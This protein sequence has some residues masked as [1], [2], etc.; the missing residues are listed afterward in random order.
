MD[1]SCKYQAIF[2]YKTDS[3]SRPR[4][5]IRNLELNNFEDVGVEDMTEFKLDLNDFDVIRLKAK[6]IDERVGDAVRFASDA[7]TTSSQQS[8]EWANSWSAT[9]TAN[10]QCNLTELNAVTSS[11]VGYYKD[12]LEDAEDLASLR[13]D[14]MSTVDA[15]VSYSN[16]ITLTTG[17]RVP[18]KC[19][20]AYDSLNTL[21]EHISELYST[22]SWK[23]LKICYIDYPEYASHTNI[24]ELTNVDD[25]KV[26][27]Q[28]YLDT[29]VSDIKTQKT[30]L[31]D[32]SYE[33]STF[34]ASVEEFEE[35]YSEC[36]STDTVEGIVDDLYSARLRTTYASFF[37]DASEIFGSLKTGL[38]ALTCL[39]G[40][41]T[42]AFPGLAPA[43]VVCAGLSTIVSGC[44][45]ASE[46]CEA[47]FTVYNDSDGDVL[48][49]TS[50]SASYYLWDKLKSTTKGSASDVVGDFVAAATG[51]QIA[52]SVASSFLTYTNTAFFEVAEDAGLKEDIYTGT[53]QIISSMQ[54]TASY[55]AEFALE[56][57]FLAGLSY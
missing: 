30:K 6:E 31:S 45:L 2:L 12:A 13:D 52:G 37:G 26:E 44:Y 8:G 55:N 53:D 19:T 46:T 21:S 43:F 35:K 22:A 39:L 34:K 3:M 56:Y 32:L 5:K 48:A 16:K 36:F 15:A 42:L 20:N 4:F 41:A 25:F 47:W 24:S 57:P 9:H 51:N 27:I 54:F 1:Q 23:N 17:G 10:V 50:D 29:I 7:E 49:A 14:V 18:S 40:V 28:G 11:F 33:Y 38:N